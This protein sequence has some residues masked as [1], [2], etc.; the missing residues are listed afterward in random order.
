MSI[1]IV[2][3]HEYHYIILLLHLMYLGQFPNCIGKMR[4][5]SERMFVYKYV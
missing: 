2:C 3:T 4:E 5:K 1:V